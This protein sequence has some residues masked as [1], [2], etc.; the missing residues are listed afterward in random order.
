VVKTG[1]T[2][3][4]VGPL[5]PFEE[6]VNEASMAVPFKE[7]EAS[8]NTL[9]QDTGLPKPSALLH[10]TSRRKAAPRKKSSAMVLLC[11]SPFSLCFTIGGFLSYYLFIL[12]NSE[13]AQIEA[14]YE[15]L[16]VKFETEVSSS[17]FMS[18]I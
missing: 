1:R 14:E 15:D 9:K 3:S 11:S 12:Q 2:A 8:Q 18:S 10:V 17:S 16:F 13:L 7:E 4:D 6:L 5:L